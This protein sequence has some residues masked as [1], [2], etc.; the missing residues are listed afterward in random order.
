MLSE[1][2]YDKAYIFSRLVYKA[3][4]AEQN[5][6]TEQLNT[7]NKR[8]MKLCNRTT[9]GTNTTS[10]NVYFTTQYIDFK[11]SIDASIAGE[12]PTN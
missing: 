6:K 12:L 3:A 1:Q 5:I 4:R 7:G 10:H 11:M 9:L 8:Q 2:K